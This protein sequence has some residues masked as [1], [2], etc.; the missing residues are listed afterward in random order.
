MRPSVAA[1]AALIAVGAALATS[2]A[3]AA[4]AGALARPAATVSQHRYGGTAPRGPAGMGRLP[5]PAPTVAV[6]P[7]PFG[8]AT[9]RRTNTVYVANVTGVS[10]FNG[11]TCNA[12]VIAGC[13]RSSVAARAGNGNIGIVVDESTNTVY[14][15]SAGDGAVS[16]IDGARCNAHV[17]AGCRRRPVQAHVGAFPSHL[18][19][20]PAHH[21]LYVTNEGADTPGHTLSMVDTARCN[22]RTT[23]GCELRPRAALVGN[24]PD[25][26][27]VDRAAHT[28]YVANGVDGTVSVLDTAR[29][30]A[31]ANRGCHGTAAPAFPLGASPVGAVVD[32][33]HHT[34]YI[35]GSVAG[36]ALGT[37]SV[38]DTASC[39]ARH[40]AGCRR[41]PATAAVGSGPIDVAYNPATRRVYVVN[42][43]DSD[44]SVID[45]SRCNATRTGGCDQKAPTLGIGFDG[46]AVAVDPTTNTIYASSQDEATV[47]VLNGAACHTGHSSGCRHPA[48]TTP[49][50][51]GPAALDVNHRTGTLYVPNQEAN[52]VS[53]VDTAACNA[54]NRSGCRRHWPTITVG[55]F[56]RSAAVDE[57]T[58]TIYTANYVG[59]SISVIDGSRCN[60]ATATGCGDASPTVGVPGGPITV[61]ID[62]ATRT[63]Y[64]ASVDGG[65][66]SVIDMRT[67]NAH[68]HSGCR[69]APTTLRV[70]T[71]PAGIL[72][73][74][75]VRTV[76]VTNRVDNTVSLIDETTCNAQRTS[77]CSTAH[78][79]V[80]VGALPR[81]M[82]VDHTTS[83]L[84]IA[85]RDDS[86]LSMLNIRS[87]NAHTAWG[88][89]STPPTVRVGLLPYGVVVDQ[90]AHTVYVGNVGDS[91]VSR[92]DGGTC[93]ANLTSGCSKL[94]P[95]VQTGGWPTNLLV[96]KVH[97]TLYV[98]QNVDA[99]VS[100][101][102]LAH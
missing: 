61:V 44:V 3:Q 22:A 35:P 49:T 58:N 47:T 76:Y 42:Q 37:L 53:V 99:T 73:D 87:C 2:P 100:V 60:A 15:A 83:T 46:G 16:V 20:D 102:R 90:A 27:A 38:I 63:L 41:R 95:T 65:T 50:G 52:T 25:G 80:T 40:V 98:S 92:I 32:Q 17:T 19:L 24:G 62:P 64:V 9:S 45:G 78:R 12:Q 1:A 30:N 75:S 56:P 31:S 11:A 26:V 13:H 94:A 18:A 67:C 34:L 28:L 14:V 81:F 96:D 8:I 84:Y 72:V 33:T 10:V 51:L 4:P 57:P 5:G 85:N 43:E 59:N 36:R 23:A 77:S 88:C 39:N 86:T 71:E 91:T 69:R 70:G 74:H 93:N 48:P 101:L 66:V 79:T 82:A 21:T 68:V 7:S 55:E 6:G 54:T 29:C 89:R 97:A